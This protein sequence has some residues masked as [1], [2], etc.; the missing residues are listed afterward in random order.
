MQI[1]PPYL[2]RLKGIG[3]W[4]VATKL[5][6]TTALVMLVLTVVIDLVV[7][8]RVQTALQSQTATDVTGSTNFLKYLLDQR[9][10][11]SVGSD[12]SLSFGAWSA[13]D[14]SIVDAVK[15][16]TRAE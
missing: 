11:P 3:T 4:R 8:N 9:G 6:L 2:D 1:M 10:A 7:V 12:G 15:R 14:L 16:N 5:L 13:G